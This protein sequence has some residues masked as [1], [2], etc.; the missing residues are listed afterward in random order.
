VEE[1]PVEAADEEDGWNCTSS[2]QVAP[3]AS[4]APTQ[5]SPVKE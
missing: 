2:V 5:V 1:G 4:G 3:G